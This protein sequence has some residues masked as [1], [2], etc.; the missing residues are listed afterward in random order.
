MPTSGNNHRNSD[1]RH[2]LTPDRHRRNRP[3]G[4]VRRVPANFGDHG[5]QVYL[6]P[7]NFCNWLSFFAG[8]YGQLTRPVG[9]KWIGGVFL[10]KKWT[11]PPTKWNETDAGLIF[12]FTFYLFAYAPNA[13]LPPAYGPA[14]SAFKDLL[15]EFKW[16][17]KE[18]WGREWVKPGRSN[19]GRRGMD[20]G[21]KPTG[22]ASTPRDV[23]S[24]FSVVIAPMMT[25][26]P[27]RQLFNAVSN[28]TSKIS[29]MF[30]LEKNP[31]S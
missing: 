30:P 6:V 2:L 12:Y 11:F 7:S 10:C 26:G 1:F 5:D 24:N 9:R 15:A 22:L 19:N 4:P 14:Y 28:V 21:G 25:E 13:P 17:R 31:P 3:M 23:P 8:H 18:E 29:A 20:R 16:R 27:L